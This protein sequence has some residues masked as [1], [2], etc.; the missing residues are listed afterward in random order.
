ML[1]HDPDFLDAHLGN[2]HANDDEFSV[3]PDYEFGHVATDDLVVQNGLDSHDHSW[4]LDHDTISQASHSATV[5]GDDFHVIAADHS[6]HEPYGHTAHTDPVASAQ[7]GLDVHVHN[8]NAHFEGDGVFESV[9]GLHLSA[10]TPVSLARQQG[11]FDDDAGTLPAALAGA[12]EVGSHSHQ[13]Y[14]ATLD[15]ITGALRRGDHVLVALDA[16]EVYRPIHDPGT[17]EPVEQANA[18]H[19]AFVREVQ[20]GPDGSTKIALSHPGSNETV[21]VDGEDFLNAWRDYG[22][23]MVTTRTGDA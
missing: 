18:P 14:E 20:P 2:A 23:L 11:W 3:S 17:G 15:E 16:N 6:L 4:G 8:P 10:E 1:D 5:P 21:V 19:T 12:N 9:T 22:N 13:H 7:H